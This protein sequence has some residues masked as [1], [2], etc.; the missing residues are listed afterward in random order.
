[1]SILNALTLAALHRNYDEHAKELGNVAPKDEPVVFLK[2]QSALR[3]VDAGSTAFADEALHHEI[4]AS[5]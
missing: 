4:E 2:S 3:S 5:C 1:M